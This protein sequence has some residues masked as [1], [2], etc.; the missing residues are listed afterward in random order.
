MNYIFLAIITMVFMGLVDYFLKIALTAGIHIYP[1]SFFVYLLMTILFGAYCIFKKKPL[2][3]Y[4]SLFIYAIIIGISIFGAT[5][6]A[7]LALREGNASVVTPIA[8]MGFLVTVLGAFFFL[9]ERFTLSKG[10]GI[11]FAIASLVLLSI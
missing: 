3:I 5:F 11:M 10:L 8:R 9:K 4:K 1:I 6:L 7:L 2:K